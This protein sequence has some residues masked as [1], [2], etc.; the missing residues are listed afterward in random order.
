[1]RWPWEKQIDCCSKAQK[2]LY[3]GWWEITNIKWYYYQ[4]FLVW[5]DTDQDGETSRK[6]VVGVNTIKNILHVRFYWLKAILYNT[7]DMWSFCFNPGRRK[8]LEPLCHMLRQR[9]CNSI[10]CLLFIFSLNCGLTLKIYWFGINL[11]SLYKIYLD[12]NTGIFLKFKHHRKYFN[13]AK[14]RRFI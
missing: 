9:H 8:R 1:M 3:C 13:V 2:K 4:H 6:V 7:Y 10:H 5:P 12:L 14:A 11:V